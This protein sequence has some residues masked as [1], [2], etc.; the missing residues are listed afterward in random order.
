MSMSR[1]DEKFASNHVIEFFERVETSL[2]PSLDLLK[3]RIKL[4]QRIH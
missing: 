4:R 1:L 3:I 2:K